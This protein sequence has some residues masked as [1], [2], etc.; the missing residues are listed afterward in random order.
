MAPPLSRLV[1]GTGAATMQDKNSAA[2]TAN[3]KKVMKQGNLFS[4]FSKKEKTKDNAPADQPVSSLVLAVTDPSNA[5]TR[6]K[7]ACL[8]KEVQTKCTSD[9]SG[10][11]RPSADVNA[12][13][14]LV[15]QVKIGDTI[16]VYWAEDDAWYEAK[17]MKRRKEKSMFFVEYN[18]DGQCEWIDLSVESFR[19][20]TDNQTSNNKTRKRRILSD[21]TDEDDFSEEAEFSMELS[22]IEDE[23]YVYKVEKIEEDDEDDQWMVTDDED[24]TI[25]KKKRKVNKKVIGPKVSDSRHVA[26]TKRSSPSLLREFSAGGG[27]I[28]V[29]QHSFSAA[30]KTPPNSSQIKNKK[31]TTPQQITPTTTSYL[32]SRSSLPVATPQALS[33]LKV[34]KTTS[35]PPPFEVGALNPAGSHVHNH[36]SFLLNLHDSAGRAPDDPH[37]DPRT[38]Q[39]IE[40]DWIHIAGKKMTDAVK[41]WWDLKAMYFDTVLLFKTGMSISFILSLFILDSSAYLPAFVFVERSFSIS[42]VNSMKCFIWMQILEYKFADCVT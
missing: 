23:D 1:P 21:D 6:E 8:T 27:S 40:R 35:Q 5:S 7:A 41:Q 9:P 17:V 12:N 2:A 33:S 38:V 29:T 37:Y 34:A 19:F 14:N 25:P 42:Q 36:L 39:I 18:I 24:E 4:F 15:E 3:C 26:C 31:L 28:S 30:G 13:D 20:L 16:E 32:S 22:N 11:L 10:S